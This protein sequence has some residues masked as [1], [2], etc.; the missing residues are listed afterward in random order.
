MRELAQCLG[1]DSGGALVGGW[2]SRGAS[3]LIHAA[4]AAAGVARLLSVG[5]VESS[6]DATSTRGRCRKERARNRGVWGRSVLRA[7]WVVRATE[8]ELKSGLCTDHQPKVHHASLWTVK[9][10]YIQSDT[11]FVNA[12]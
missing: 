4:R 2:T 7:R 10:R 9:G 5:D 11:D 12:P 6:I 8:A 1:V 3:F